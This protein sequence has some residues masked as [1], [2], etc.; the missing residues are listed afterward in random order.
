MRDADKP[1][2]RE[3]LSANLRE[4]MKARP[5]LGT[6]KKVANASKSNLSNGKVGRIY[7]ASHTTDIDTLQHLAD[8]F[9]VEPWQLL[10]AGLNPL[11][12][13]RLADAFVLAQILD[14]VRSNT[15]AEKSDSTQAR[16]AHQVKKRAGTTSAPSPAFDKALRNAGSS[17]AGREVGKVQKPRTRRGM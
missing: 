15:P 4:L 10:V 9:G 8:V 16:H 7:A 13:P 2:P 11:A 3:V 14:A 5:D 17:N 6:I 1:S 12:L